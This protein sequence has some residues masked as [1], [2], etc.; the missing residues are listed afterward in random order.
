MSGVFYQGE[1]LTASN[2]ESGI[3]T[4]TNQVLTAPGPIGSATPNTLN[5]IVTATGSTTGR[6]LAT[7]FAEV[8][9]VLDYGADPTGVAD[10]TAAIQAAVTTAASRGG[11]VIELPAGTLSVSGTVLV[12]ASNIV[13]RGKGSGATV[14]SVTSATANTFTFAGTSAP[15]IYDCGMFDL[16]FVQAVPR[17]AGVTISLSLCN[18]FVADRVY[19]DAAWQ[20]WDIY[21][22]NNITLRDC[23]CTNVRGPIGIKWHAPADG[24]ARSDVLILMSVTINMNNNGGTGIVL[25]GMVQT[26]RTFGCGIL[27]AVTGLQVLNSALS[28]SNFPG[29]IYLWDMEIDGNTGVACD[30][31]AGAQIE[32]NGCDFFNVATATGPV[33][34]VLS[35]AGASD[36]NSI[37]ISNSRLAGGQ[38]QALAFNGR[39]LTLTGSMLADGSGTA[40]NCIDIQATA[41][42][43]MIVG[44]QIGQFWGATINKYPFGIGITAGATRVFISGNSFYGCNGEVDNLSSAQVFIGP[45]LDRSGVPGLPPSTTYTSENNTGDFRV[46]LQ[47]TSTGANVS[48]SRELSTGTANSF[49]IQMLHDN[50]GAP[51]LQDSLGS[52]VTARY[53]DAPVQYFRDASANTKLTI[54]ETDVQATVPIV[55]PSYTVA[56]LPTGMPTGARAIVTDATSPTFL[57]A[58]TGGGAVKCPVLYNG[59]AWVAG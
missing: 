59:S 1:T 12:Q 16:S 46:T 29:F 57:G 4:I 19:V 28:T 36:T 10:S 2:L 45:Y 43:V 39:N 53:F 52:G 14:I 33:V 5:G 51:Y 6:T 47:N 58:L 41:Q 31:Q 26:L 50:A 54:A 30:I 25:D 8:V 44:N 11:G 27:D 37:R 20:A 21:V 9:N 7:R 35:D 23:L 22:T 55:V 13:F 3:E 48:S 49:A 34:R 24:S 42:D 32:M 18:Q 40:Y 15:G 56:T 38:Q 17:T